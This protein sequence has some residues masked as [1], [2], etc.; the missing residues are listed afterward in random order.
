MRQSWWNVAKRVVGKR[1]TAAVALVAYLATSSGLPLPVAAAQKDRSRPYPCMDDP[2][3]CTSPE[4][5]WRNCQHHTAA[6]RWAWADAHNVRP[7]DY[8]EVPAAGH[9]EAGA[10]VEEHHHHHHDGAGEHAP[11]ATSHHGMG[12]ASPLHFKGFA[13]LWVDA[14]TTPAPSTVAWR[15]AFVLAE[16]LTYSD[17]FASRLSQMPPSPPP[18]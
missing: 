18:R 14:G 6:E 12:G 3:G 4:E 16:R 1:L 5:C 7:P 9:E 17:Q 11:A 2:W 15:P 8:A 10:V 13:T